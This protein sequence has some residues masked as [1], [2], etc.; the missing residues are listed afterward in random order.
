MDLGFKK[1][2]F[3]VKLIAIILLIPFMLNIVLFQFTTKITYQGG[4]WLSYW[5]SYLGGALSGV[6]AFMVARM[7]ILADRRRKG[8][9]LI[10]NQLPA[11]I[12]VKLELE[13]IKS[14]I[15]KAMELRS[16]YTR[17]YENEERNPDEIAIEIELLD[18]EK[19]TYL[20][21]ILDVD[22]QVKLI[23]LKDFYEKWSVALKY[24]GIKE[25]HFYNLL[26]LETGV[27]AFSPGSSIEQNEAF[28]RLSNDIP[29]YGKIR[30]EGFEKLDNGYKDSV[31]DLLKKV[32]AYIHG[33]EKAKDRFENG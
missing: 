12:R 6:V 28:H 27:P 13:K 24:D 11:L 29:S 23:E 21:R 16:K 15:D 4:D 1:K 8:Y 5:G 17:L 10:L 3:W 18:K 25:R 32:R 7:T 30:L 20:D 2:F 33:I 14:N 22:L 9:E 19:W 31:E 26:S